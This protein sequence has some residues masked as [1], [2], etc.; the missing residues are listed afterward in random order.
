MMASLYQRESGKGRG[1]LNVGRGTALDEKKVA[2]LDGRI[3]AHVVADAAP[4]VVC[5]GEQVAHHVWFLVVDS[6]LV[7]RHVEHGLLRMMWI[8]VHGNQQVGGVSSMGE[9]ERFGDARRHGVAARV[10]PLDQRIVRRLAVEENGGVLA[11]VKAE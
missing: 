7:N 4:G 8:G 3:E 5:S 1:T 10:G 6:H 2:G 11:R 9:P